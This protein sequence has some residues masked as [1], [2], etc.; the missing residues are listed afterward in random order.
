MADNRTTILQDDGDRFALDHGGVA[1]H[2]SDQQPSIRHDVNGVVAHRTLPG[3]ALVHMV[4]WEE[5]PCAVELSGK[6]TLAGDPDAPVQVRMRHEFANDH[7][8]TLAVEPVDH[9]VHVDT[10]L[11]KPVHHALQM[12]TPL[13]VR[14]CNP[15][16]IA[17]DYRLDIDLG[18]NRV[19]GIRLTG[20]TVA[21]P[22]PCDPPCPAAGPE[23]RHP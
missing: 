1:L 20:A 9:T 6:V 15:W 2:G 5:E 13:E 19:I 16:H 3:Q 23:G 4:C 21:T 22:Q 7:H 11:D 12:R 10:A 18:R 8:Q 14:F 17:S